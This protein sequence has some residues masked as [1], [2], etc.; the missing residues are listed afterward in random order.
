M[1]FA[2][3]DGLDFGIKYA[4]GLIDCEN[5]DINWYVHYY[6]YWFEAF[7]YWDGE[8]IYIY[9]YM[10]LWTQGNFPDSV[11]IEAACASPDEVMMLMIMIM[12]MKIINMMIMIMMIMIMMIMIMIIMIMIIMIMIIM[13][14]MIIMKMVIIWLGWL[15]WWRLWWWYERGRMHCSK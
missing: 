10:L 3:D 14:M 9:K 12:T 5:S 1:I 11:T 7:V 13:I 15:W 8:Y 2:W 4:E 6:H